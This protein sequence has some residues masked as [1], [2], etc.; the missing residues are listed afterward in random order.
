[1]TTDCK[2]VLETT[3]NSRIA[4]T[5]DF[6]DSAVGARVFHTLLFCNTSLISD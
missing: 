4:K 5:E 2:N 3:P 1:M 6:S